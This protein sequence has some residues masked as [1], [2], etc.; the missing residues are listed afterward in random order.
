MYTHGH[1]T[2]GSQR[3]GTPNSR[4]DEI[5]NFVKVHEDVSILYDSIL[6]P[7]S[8]I[9]PAQLYKTDFKAKLMQKTHLEKLFKRK[10]KASARDTASESD[11]ADSGKGESD[12][13]TINPAGGPKCDET[14]LRLGEFSFSRFTGKPQ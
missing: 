3:P 13:D 10:Y 5:E 2:D 1:S 11:H 4:C 9:G 8:S 7:R 14:C 6:T 12:H